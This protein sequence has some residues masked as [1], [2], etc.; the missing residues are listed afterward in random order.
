M[1][2]RLLIVVIMLLI[3]TSAFADSKYK[4]GFYES[5]FLG[6]ENLLLPKFTEIAST[7]T[8]FVNYYN[9]VYVKPF[10]GV[11]SLNYKFKTKDINIPRA[12]NSS[13]TWQIFR[14]YAK[15]RNAKIYAWNN[16]YDWI[17][18]ASV[19]GKIEAAL[20][21]ETKYEP[22]KGNKVFDPY[23]VKAYYLTPEGFDE[24][25]ANLGET[26]KLYDDQKKLIDIS[27]NK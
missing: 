11:K 7:A 19:K 4:E 13:K 15:G 26:G 8:D 25:I 27:N 23:I 24:Y 3:G 5:G 9:S 1:K 18:T 14:E 12:G 22:V 10:E 17:I 16:N 21:Y 2:T 20:Y 6:S